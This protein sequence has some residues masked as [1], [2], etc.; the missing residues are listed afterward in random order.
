MNTGADLSGPDFRYR[1]LRDTETRRD[2]ALAPG[3]VTD[4]HDILIGQFRILV[5]ESSRKS[6]R[7]QPRPMPV[8]PRLALRTSSRAVSPLLDLVSGVIGRG[9]REDVGGVTARRV[10]TTMQ[11]PGLAVRQRSI[12]ERPRKDVGLDLLV[13]GPEAAVVVRWWPDHACEPRPA[14]IRA[15]AINLGPETGDD[16]SWC[17]LRSS[18][19]APPC[20]VV[21][22]R[23]RTQSSVGSAH[24]TTTHN[25]GPIGYVERVAQ[26][27]RLVVRDRVSA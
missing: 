13:P 18:H 21:R 17:R 20:G 2:F 1:L 11:P 26:H 5:R 8:A 12:S 27:A 25:L 23:P 22:N 4:Q 24:S 6:F 14:L 10:V 9:A 16:L 15:S 19:V 3:G 7:M